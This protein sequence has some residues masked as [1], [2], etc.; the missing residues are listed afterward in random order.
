MRRAGS[1]QVI[2]ISHTFWKQQFDSDPG[3]VGK[4]VTLNRNPYT[5]VGVAPEG[6]SG[7]SML[8]GEVRFP[9]RN[10]GYPAAIF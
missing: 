5:I 2:V 9:S 8:G 6:F 7:A 3:V 10:N 4:T 1:G